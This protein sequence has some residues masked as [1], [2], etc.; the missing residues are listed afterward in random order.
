MAP[1]GEHRGYLF[2]GLACLILLLPLLWVLRPDSKREAADAEHRERAFAPTEITPPTLSSPSEPPDFV[3]GPE[4]SPRISERAG[5]VATL[6]LPTGIEL[7]DLGLVLDNIEPG[8]AAELRRNA[9]GVLQDA[10]GVALDGARPTRPISVLM[11]DPIT[12]P[13]PFAVL[14]EVED[15]DALRKAVPASKSGLR[16]RGGLALLGPPA[17]LDAVEDYA[18]TNLGTPPEHSELIVYPASLATVVAPLIQEQLDKMANDP[19]KALAESLA[20][21]LLT[22]LDSCDRIVVSVDAGRRSTDAFVHLYPRPGTTLQT[23]IAAQVPATHDLLAKLPAGE[24]ASIISGTVR[25]G[26]ATEGML[27]A[28]GLT[29]ASVMPGVLDATQWAA[30]FEPLVAT[31]DGRFAAMIG[32]GA[33]P[34]SLPQSWVLY[35]SED[36]AAT[37]ASMRTLMEF[38]AAVSAHVWGG[39]IKATARPELELHD[40]VSIDRLDIT[41]DHSSLPAHVRASLDAS[42]PRLTQGQEFAAFDGVMAMG[43][44]GEVAMMIDAV[45]GRSS[46]Q[47]SDDIAHALANS[48]A[49]GESVFLWLDFLPAEPRPGAPT[50]PRERSVIGVGKQGEA[51]SLHVSLR[52]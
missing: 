11:A 7:V 27:G 10:A 41:I 43:G 17:V 39:R 8:F 48:S 40:G 15:I 23:F 44:A 38:T 3:R 19:D 34:P 5:V 50:A 30:K 2:A 31:S 9:P 16:E 29:C 36:E 42:D 20:A 1:R 33:E 28:L 32:Q 51:L 22:L 6:Q 47:P 12:H 46:Y 45:R 35:G 18:F 4:D 26:G 24:P 37:L 14:V 13:H 25:G 21:M 52:R 49:L